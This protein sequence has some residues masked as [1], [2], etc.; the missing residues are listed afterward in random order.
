M[1]GYTATREI[2][3][4]E[5]EHPERPSTPIVALTANAFQGD[6]DECRAAG[7]DDFLTKPVTKDAMKKA[8]DRWIKLVT[9]PEKAQ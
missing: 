6:E 4:W 7:M 3:R 8:L 1:D 2:R 5:S 9:A